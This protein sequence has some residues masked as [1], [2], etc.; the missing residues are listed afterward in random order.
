M[1]KRV[2]LGKTSRRPYST[3]IAVLYSRFK[4]KASST[5]KLIIKLWQMPHNLFEINPFDL[6]TLGLNIVNL[7]LRSTSNT[8][9]HQT[10]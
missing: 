7:L 6:S 8:G 3:E 10:P 1:D 9:G 2:R 4:R 5:L